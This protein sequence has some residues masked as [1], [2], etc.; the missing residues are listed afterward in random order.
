MKKLIALLIP[1]LLV[2]C[3]VSKK[4]Y[5]LPKAMLPHV[6]IEVAERCDRGQRLYNINC[7]GCHNVSKGRKTIIP[8]FDQQQLQG[9]T[10]RVANK[11]HES[12]MPDSLVSEEELVLISTF[13]MYKKPSGFPCM[14]NK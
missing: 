6:R 13:L 8:D 4:N 7:S 9:Y 3:A 12:S 2:T 1:C 11:R 5:E 14:T 10:I